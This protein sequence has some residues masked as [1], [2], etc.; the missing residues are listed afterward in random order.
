M[1]TDKKASQN[2]FFAAIVFALASEALASSKSEEEKQTVANLVKIAE[3]VYGA[4]APSLKLVKRVSRAVHSTLKLFVDSRD[5]TYHI[6]KV[7]LALHGATQIALDEGLISTDAALV[8]Q[9]AL[10]LENKCSINDE[11]WIK[12]KQSADKRIDGIVE[13]V[14][15]I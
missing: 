14:K 4:Y 15:N 3:V 1:I 5:N 11:D 7:F 13:I 12:L 2:A 10:D 8:V 6:R 9:D